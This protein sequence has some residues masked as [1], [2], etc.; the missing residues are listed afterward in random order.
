MDL[1]NLHQFIS[2]DKLLQEYPQELIMEYFFQ[3]TVNLK[4]FYLNPYREDKSP[5][6]KF[7]YTRKGV[8]VFNDYAL[9]KQYDCFQIAE[10]RVGEKITSTEIYNLLANKNRKDLP[11]PK[12]K[13]FCEENAQEKTEIDVKIMPFNEADLTYWAQFNIFL[14]TLKKYN[15]RKV[16]RAWINKKLIYIDLDKDPCYRY[17][18]DDR[19]KLYRPLSKKYKFRNNYVKDLEGTSVLPETGNK[20]VITKALK[21]VMLFDSIGVRA[22][23]PRSE[24]SLISAESM[25]NL[26]ERFKEVFLWFD[27][28]EVGIYRANILYD[29]Y[30]EQGLILLNH[31]AHLGKDTSDIVKNNGINKLIEICKQSKI[32]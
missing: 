18:E 22:V 9:N 28:D 14:P 19:F 6:C 21:D 29:K 32:L 10:E 15:I 31:G 3:D 27:Q 25:N 4:N 5:S 11:K 23:C 30:K 8:L 26:F 7:F 24:S 20:I 12:I 17:V 2:K 1:I 16:E 13:Y